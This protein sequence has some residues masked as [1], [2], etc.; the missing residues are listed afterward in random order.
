MTCITFDAAAPLLL[1]VDAVEVGGLSSGTI[2]PPVSSAAATETFSDLILKFV[3]FEAT[4]RLLEAVTEA[5]DCS[6]FLQRS[7]SLAL[8]SLELLD[9]Q[10]NEFHERVKIDF[11]TSFLKAE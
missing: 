2:L 1:A 11:P 4:G 5:V 8:P 3:G 10:L 7:I 9:F 6:N